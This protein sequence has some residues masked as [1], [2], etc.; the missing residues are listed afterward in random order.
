[1]FR[2][3]VLLYLE[4]G[5]RF[6]YLSNLWNYLTHCCQAVV[7]LCA[8]LSHK[9]REIAKSSGV[10]P[11]PAHGFMV[12]VGTIEASLMI[13]WDGIHACFLADDFFY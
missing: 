5:C 8:H 3:I 1:M 4:F 9:P 12:C 7:P 6:A 10:L 11:G 13:F 2:D